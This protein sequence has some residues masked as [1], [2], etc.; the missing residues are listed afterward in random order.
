MGV[1]SFYRWLSEKYPRVVSDVI[2]AE[3]VVVDGVEVPTDTS[4]ANPNAVEYD[5]LY[6]DMNGLIHPCCHPEDKP[7][8]ASEEEMIANVFQYIDR[9]FGMVRPRR[10]L[11]MAIDGVAPRAKM[12]QQRSRRFRAAQEMSQRKAKENEIRDAWEKEG[13]PLP[14]IK[15]DRWDHNVITPGT[16]FMAK[17]SQ[18]LTF[19]VNDRITSD[20][21]WAD[22]QVIYSDANV[23]G[24]GEHKIMQFIRQQRARPG[25]PPNLRHVVYGMDADL[26]MLSLATHEPHFTIIRETVLFGKQKGCHT[27]GQQG[28]FAADCQGKAKTKETEFDE[29]TA[30][31]DSPFQFLSISVLREYLAS[32]LYVEDLPFQ[33]DLERVI[34]DFVF[35]CFFVGND[36]LPHLPSLEIREGALDDLIRLYKAKLPL[37]GGYLTNAGEVNLSRVDVIF[38]EIGMQEPEL[39]RRR[40]RQEERNKRRQEQQERDRQSKADALK[41]SRSESALLGEDDK[42]RRKKSRRSGIAADDAVG[43]IRPI[44][45]ERRVIKPGNIVTQGSSVSANQAAASDLRARL[46]SVSPAASAEAPVDNDKE[47]ASDPSTAA[48]EVLADNDAEAQEQEEEDVAAPSSS[49]SDEDEVLADLKQAAAHHDEYALF[50]KKAV[51]EMNRVPDAPDTLRFHEQGYKDRYYK[52]KFGYDRTANH[53]EIVEIARCYTQGLRWVMLYYYRGCQSWEWFYP[54]HYAPF[55]SDLRNI[56]QFDVQLT[57]GKPFSPL[58]QLMGVLPAASSHCLP[59]AYRDL[60]TR[61]DSPILHFYPEDFAVDLN[62]KKWAWQAVVL[63][64]FI[65]QNLLL[66][67]LETVRPTLND[68]EKARDSTGSDYLY[69]NASHVVGIEISALY[70]KHK[71]S[72]EMLNSAGTHIAGDKSV[73]VTG[74]LKPYPKAALPSSR[75]TLNL[76]PFSRALSHNR[77]ISAI[78][79]HPAPVEHRCQLL[80]GTVV[81]E[82]VLKP[83]DFSS[84]TSFRRYGGRSLMFDA[85]G[86]GGRQPQAKLS[87][88]G[89]RMAQQALP[90]RGSEDDRYRYY[91]RPSEPSYSYT[92]YGRQAGYDDRRSNRQ[93]YPPS[94]QVYSNSSNNYA[95]RR[96]QASDDVAAYS[97]RRYESYSSRDQYYDYQSGSSYGYNS[98]NDGR[99]YPQRGPDPYQARDDSRYAPYVPRGPP[100]D[101]S[102]RPQ[103]QRRPPSSARR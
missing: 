76:G 72:A 79:E 94:S 32:E 46:S 30:V 98:Y 45:P 73:G 80:P 8:P 3:R 17:L 49:S 1:P 35:L 101:D 18:A 47:E 93:P 6:L 43:G 74:K 65:D 84:V 36:F 11:Y 68:V 85:G 60:M 100:L 2:E 91:G 31:K 15:G 9:I 70:L 95:D 33:W 71:T 10:L 42:E 75:V 26:I 14:P 59:P 25:Y 67:T 90:T 28:H 92:N 61:S 29:T 38:D 69:T 48:A 64:P 22:V 5:C 83:E 82:P 12:N 96:Y 54:Y 57:L 88:A 86:G 20:P 63:L 78:F 102:R 51:E 55:A 103:P 58:S 37:L 23:P 16:P 53:D 40:H 56:D 62:G 50:V 41:R 66:E 44:M 81:A 89:V 13:R 77:A 87:S 19:Y 52:A 21:G 99:R 7:Q 4:Q 27:C 39:L 24:E 34:D 97:H